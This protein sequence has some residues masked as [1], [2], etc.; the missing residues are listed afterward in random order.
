MTDRSTIV[1]VQGS[2]VPYHAALAWQHEAA[3]LVRRDGGCEAL[4]LIEH[5]PVYTMGRR[6]GRASLLVP[7]EELRAPVV[8]TERGGDLT[9]HGPGQ[10]VG[11]PILN[12]RRRGLRAA[13]YVRLL[14]AS[15]I[16]ALDD[17][18]LAAEV[19]AG[20]PGVWV[21]DA[22]IAAIGVAIRGGVSMHGF[23]LNVAPDLTWFDAITPCGLA[24]ATVTSLAAELPEAPTMDVVI[25]AVRAAL[26]R[27]LS[28]TFDPL[29]SPFTEAVPA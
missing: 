11:Y 24:D 13:D 9:W 3:D 23:A 17:V 25:E 21:G 4:A 7:V 15:V 5:A 19:V 18:G 2:A 10:L 28:S 26:G 27:R 29:T 16:E 6:G 14:E 1:L 22:K 20:R 8:D 12:L